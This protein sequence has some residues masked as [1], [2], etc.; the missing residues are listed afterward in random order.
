MKNEKIDTLFAPE[1]TESNTGFSIS[2][3]SVF[4][5]TTTPTVEFWIF[6]PSG[7]RIAVFEGQEN[8]K[9]A[10]AAF[11]GIESDFIERVQTFLKKEYRHF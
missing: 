2:K 6:N 8:E 9:N 11:R 3:I 5:T 1:T 10:M 4:G 7:K